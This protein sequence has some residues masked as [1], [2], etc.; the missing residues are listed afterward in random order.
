MDLLDL[1]L[2]QEDMDYDGSL[3]HFIQLAEVDTR[4]RN[5]AMRFSGNTKQ[6]DQWNRRIERMRKSFQ[7]ENSTLRKRY[8]EGLEEIEHGSPCLQIQ[9]PYSFLHRRV[10]TELLGSGSD[11][12][13]QSKKPHKGRPSSAPLPAQRKAKSACR[14]A[15][16]WDS[17]H[18]DVLRRTRS[19]TRQRHAADCQEGLIRWS[20][21]AM[22]EMICEQGLDNSPVCLTP[23]SLTED[24][25]ESR[26]PANSAPEPNFHDVISPIHSEMLRRGHCRA[27][28]VGGKAVE[29]VEAM[30]TEDILARHASGMQDWSK[31]RHR[32][33]HNNVLQ[34]RRMI[35]A[36]RRQAEEERAFYQRRDKLVKNAQTIRV[37]LRAKEK[38]LIYTDRFSKPFQQYVKKEPPDTRDKYTGGPRHAKSDAQEK[39]AAEMVIRHWRNYK[40]GGLERCLQEHRRQ[41]REAQLAAEEK[42]RQ[43]RE[44]E[45]EE[46]RRRA[47]LARAYRR[48]PE[49]FPHSD[50]ARLLHLVRTGDAA[51]L[52]LSGDASV[53]VH[54]ASLARE[55]ARHQALFAAARAGNVPM[56]E[57]LVDVV[58]FSVHWLE[59]TTR[60]TLLHAA[61]AG[62]H[63]EACAWLLSRGVDAAVTDGSGRT[64]LQ[65]AGFYAA[66]IIQASNVT[67][68]KRRS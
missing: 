2:G 61:A 36:K 53:L 24:E 10:K 47:A 25:E 42:A 49:R 16:D 46:E 35:A 30:V 27:E 65:V 22:S 41:K 32:Y 50:D 34:Q 29:E 11:P 68:A 12:G 7:G 14:P 66:E 23:E 33:L 54:A 1:E 45:E 64:A 56:L 67:L 39:A 3:E 59:P 26:P 51:E 62:N 57:A 8:E 52:T 9:S 17:G 6:L 63:A 4:R 28:V 37:Y 58:G 48:N 44:A 5:M 21:L 40:G 20:R 43:E 60:E 55:A 18:E 38:G 15:P 31:A 13:L 19:V